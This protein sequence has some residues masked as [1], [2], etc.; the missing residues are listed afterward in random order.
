MSKP[1]ASINPRIIEN[2]KKEFL[3]HGFE[4]ASLNTICANAGV[5][6]GALYKRYSGKLELFEALVSSV[7]HDIDVFFDQVEQRDYHLF[8]NGTLEAMWDISEK[9]YEE[10]V[11]F[12]YDRH[13]AIKLLL[14]SSEGT[15]YSGFIHD[16]AEKHTKKT[17]DFLNEVKLRGLPANDVSEDELHILTSAYWCSMFEPIIHDFSKEKALRYVHTL[18]KFLNWQAVFGF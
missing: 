11:E 13:D 8:D 3:S 12:L 9:T 2:A 6:T 10:W 18:I 5:T 1:D 17:M 15:P 16:I 4:K 14:C 7:L